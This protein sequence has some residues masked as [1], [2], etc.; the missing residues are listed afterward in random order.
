VTVLF[1]KPHPGNFILSEDDEGRLSRD[2]V[3]IASGAGRLLPGTVLGLA[4]TTHKYSPSPATATDGT[5][6]AIAV[7][8]GEVDATTADVTAVVITRH[9]EVNHFGLIYHASVDDD[10][11]KAVKRDQLRAA[12]II[13]R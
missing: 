8:V 13:V 12:G 4:A 6:T 10:D 3:V 9:A 5:D 2:N 7:L 1:E 11:K